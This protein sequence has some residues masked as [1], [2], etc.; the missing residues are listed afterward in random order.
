MQDAQEILD[1]D[2]SGLKPSEWQ[3][4]LAQMAEENGMYQPLGDRHFATFIDQGNTL[5]VSFESM[6]GI[7]SLSEQALP[8]GFDL[9]RTLG[10]SHLCL[11]SK[12]ETWFRD[13]DIFGFMDQLIDDGFFDEFDKVVFYGAGPCAYAAAAFSVAAPSASVVLVQP[14]ATLDP[15]LAGWDDRFTD[16]R[17]TSFTDRYGYAPDMIEAAQDVH[18]IYDPREHLDA[19]HAA[20]FRAPNVDLLPLPFMGAAIQSRLIQMEVLYRV[21][22]LAG[23]NRLSRLSFYKLLRARRDHRGYLRDLLNTLDQNDRPTLSY[24]LCRNVCDRMRAPRFRTRLE[25]LEQSMQDSPAD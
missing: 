8:L 4:A 11:V 6:G 10:W 1:R 5:L 25:Q 18:V 12:G 9:V 7:Q 2:L 15:R 3:D 17:K 22:S 23:T 20:L 13:E 16:M 19:M 21:I 14:Q 24:M